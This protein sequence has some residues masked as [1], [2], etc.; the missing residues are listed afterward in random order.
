[1]IKSILGCETFEK[2]GISESE[3]KKMEMMKD[4]SRKHL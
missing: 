2:M 1:L 4:D 3:R